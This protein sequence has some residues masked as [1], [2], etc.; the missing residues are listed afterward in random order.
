[1]AAD[2]SL[3]FRG[4]DGTDLTALTPDEG[5]GPWAKGTLT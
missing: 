2:W 4:A 1:M 3:T 5:L